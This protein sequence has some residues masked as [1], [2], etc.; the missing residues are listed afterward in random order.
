MHNVLILGGSG[1]LGTAIINELKK[2]S[3]FK[4]YATYFQSRPKQL[5][6]DGNFKLNIEDLNKISNILNISQPQTI[7]SCLRGDYTQQ[8]ALHIKIAKYLKKTHGK[9]YF[10]S[11]ANVFDYDLTKPYAEDDLPKSSSAYGTFK[12]SCENKILEILHDNACILRLPQVFGKAA[13][14]MNHLLN[15]LRL[16]EK[17]VVYPNLFFNINIDTIVAKQL[18]YIITRN[19]TGIFHLATGDIVNQKDF[20]RQLVTG[21][22]F[23]NVR[24]Q[25]SFAEK[26]YFALSTKRGAELPDWLKLMNISAI[27]YLINKTPISNHKT[28]TN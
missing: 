10:F 17:V 20:Y 24:F 16:N 3:R 12:L 15:S 27:D 2:H 19:L 6:L 9:L 25:E 26:G 23:T 11:T 13:P 14:R 8:L 7:V 18:C 4:V 28:G 21:L 1:F 22:G 5:I